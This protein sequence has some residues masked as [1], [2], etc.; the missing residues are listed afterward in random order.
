MCSDELE[1]RARSSP[2]KACE[3]RRRESRAAQSRELCQHR[4]ALLVRLLLLLLWLLAPVSALAQTPRDPLHTPVRSH[5]ASAET[6][7]P[8]ELLQTARIVLGDLAEVTADGTM[9]LH[10][11]GALLRLELRHEAEREQLL[12]VASAEGV[13]VLGARSKSSSYAADR[14]L[15]L[16]LRELL[17]PLTK[18][19]APAPRAA[20]ERPPHD[21]ATLRAVRWSLEAGFALSSP[22]GT[23]GAAPRVLAML[24]LRVREPTRSFAARLGGSITPVAL[25][26]EGALASSHV[27]ERSLMVD[28]AILWGDVVR[29]GP[30]A[31]VGASSLAIESQPL[32]GPMVRDAKW[33]ALLGAGVELQWQLSRFVFWRAASALELELP[34]QRWTFGG[35]AAADSGGWR[36][37]GQLGLGVEL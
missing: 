4:P 5:H 2:L 36:I 10:D 34:R 16:K 9:R 7:L 17:T 8:P 14:E 22:R 3:G 21:A 12:Q 15:L 28:G 6:S 11:G 27:A 18:S 24:G 25:S 31:R 29:I 37:T 35:T 23:L 26:S 1:R 33:S 13:V 30:L 32:T 20:P 19:A